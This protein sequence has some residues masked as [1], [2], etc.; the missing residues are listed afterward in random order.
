MANVKERMLKAEEK[1]LITREPPPPPHKAVKLVSL[2]KHLQARKGVAR[3][4]Q[5][6]E[7]GKS[8]A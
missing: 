1:E 6:P 4:I 8:T 7:R 2:Q 5:S 3:Y